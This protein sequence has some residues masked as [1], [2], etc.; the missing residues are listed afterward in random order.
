MQILTPPVQ[1]VL[2]PQIVDI[3]IDVIN[4]GIM[5]HLLGGL[6]LTDFTKGA[7]FRPADRLSGADATDDEYLSPGDERYALLAALGTI[8]SWYEQKA[9]LETK[10]AADGRRKKPTKADKTTSK[11][12]KFPGLKPHD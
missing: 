12:L 6:I 3:P 8:R 2:Q 4:R 11:V 7:F 10:G 9:E 5:L 1:I